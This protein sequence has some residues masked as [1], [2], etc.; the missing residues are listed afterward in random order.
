MQVVVL[1]GA[2]ISAA[3]GIATF[4]D[5]DGL[6]SK[7]DYRE[8]AT[9]EGF[10]ADPFKVHAF[11]NLRRAAL[12]TVAPNVAHRA[13]ADWEDEIVAGGGSF[14]LVTQNVDDLH[15]RAGSRNLLA[16]HGALDRIRCLQCG[17]TRSWTGDL[18]TDTPCAACGSAGGL[19]PDVVWFGEMPRHLPEIEEALA[20]ADLFIAIGTSG[21]VYPAAGFVA[22]A[23]QFGA[24]TVELNK[25]PSQTA[26]LFDEGHYGPA[27]TIVPQF[28]AGRAARSQP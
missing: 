12:P 5:A 9:P 11:Y 28:I 18:H 8:V 3:S 23:R 1:T 13:L 4:R 26:G 14:L 15:R 20:T 6:W 10:A 19:R 17:D 7:Y 16:M 2:G 25:E 21:T 27:E 24:R 22:E